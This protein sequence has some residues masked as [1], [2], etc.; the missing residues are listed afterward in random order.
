MDTHRAQHDPWDESLADW[1]PAES[2]PNLRFEREQ[3]GQQQLQYDLQSQLQHHP[4][5]HQHQQQHQQPPPQQP[6]QQAARAEPEPLQPVLLP[7][8]VTM[9]A[10][11]G[12]LGER[13]ARHG[14]CTDVVHA[15]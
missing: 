4:R 6:Q 1:E 12:L 14:A 7:A 15:S 2:D 8:D 13:K 11:A 5:A 9:R 10:L 3:Y